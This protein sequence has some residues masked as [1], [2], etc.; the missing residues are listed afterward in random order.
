MTDEAKPDNPDKD[1]PQPRRPGE[2]KK[3]GPNKWKT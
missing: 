1:K 2:K 3:R